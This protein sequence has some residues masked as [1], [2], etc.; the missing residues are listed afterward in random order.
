MSAR[1]SRTL[2]EYVPAESGDK[3]KKPR[4][5]PERSDALRIDLPFEE[6]LAAALET[7]PEVPKGSERR[8]PKQ[9]GAAK[10]GRQAGGERPRR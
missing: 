3:R 8:A 4:K 1:G 10:Q 9:R 6:A 5:L 7:V 2:C